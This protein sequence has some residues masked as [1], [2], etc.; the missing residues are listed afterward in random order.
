[1]GDLKQKFTETVSYIKR[2]SDFEPRTGLILGSGLG[3]L[4][5][6][7]DTAAVIEYKDIPHF[8][9]PTVAGHKGRLL[10]GRIRGCNVICMQGRFHFYEGYSMRQVIYPV[11]VMKMLGAGIIIVTNAA[12]GINTSFSPGDLMLIND[13]INLMGTNPLIGENDDETGDRFPD[14]SQAYNGELRR[15]AISAA[16]NAGLDLKQGVYAALTGPSYETPAEI[17]MLKAIGADAVG[18][19]TVPEVIAANHCG[20]KVLG[21]S[22]ITNMASGIT[23]RP[24]SHSEVIK[25]TEQA[26][27]R[28]TLL[29]KSVIGSL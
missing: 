18:M 17:G 23:Q 19:S 25:T 13:H 8:P 20:L 3:G 5:D 12:G 11:R 26:N 15:L 9:V 14:M 27:S 1:L 4:A 7:I 10:M 6:E 28:F 22:C 21:I 29:L 2:V 16:A 24:L